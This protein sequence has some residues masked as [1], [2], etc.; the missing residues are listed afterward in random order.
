MWARC[1]LH[2]CYKT[3]LLL[4]LCAFHIELK[5]NMECE[6]MWME[7]LITYC[8]SANFSSWSNDLFIVA[9]AFYGIFH[10][11]FEKTIYYTPGNSRCFHKCTSKHKNDTNR[12]RILSGVK[13]G[14]LFFHSVCFGSP[15]LLGWEAVSTKT[16]SGTNLSKAGTTL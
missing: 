1:N 11:V 14:E 2:F 13:E 6:G 8:T 15:S 9:L 4:L 16:L 5:K 7:L 12:D 3:L 10:K